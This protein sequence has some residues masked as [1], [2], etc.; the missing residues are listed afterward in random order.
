MKPRDTRRDPS[1]E[2]SGLD[3]RSPALTIYA[4][5]RNAKS[6]EALTSSEAG[7]R[8]LS[9]RSYTTRQTISRLGERRAPSSQVARK[10][11]RRTVSGDLRIGPGWAYARR[12]SVSP[13]RWADSRTT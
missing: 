6:A 10:P 7:P 8:R 13:L 4:A 12:S 5:E 11:A 3:R 2:M 9:S 1:S